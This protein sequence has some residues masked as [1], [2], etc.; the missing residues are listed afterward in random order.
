MAND[1]I[2][3]APSILSAD[4]AHLDD[5][6]QALEGAGIDRVHVDVMDGHFVPPITMGPVIVDAVRSA[7]ELPIEVHL[8]VDRPGDHVEPFID[9][10][11]ERLIVHRE[12]APHLHR[13][14]ETIHA[15]GAEAGVAINP[16]T[17]VH[18]LDAILDDID[19]ALAMTVNPGYAGQAFL[20][21][22]VPKL[23]QLA[24]RTAH[25]NPACE[26]EVDGGVS[27]D[28]APQAVDAGATVLVAA[29]AIFKH[30]EGIRGGV[31][32]VRA[33]VR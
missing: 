10:G 2:R 25:R 14:V 20:P 11:A 1:E 29:S 13:L 7:C 3:I 19:L 21:S 27:A 26:I 23:E 16:A 24:Q 15:Q 5:E 4:F 33:A 32:A 22:V 6:L 28:T 12:V 30:P 31:D 17:P 8:M 18:T 9:A